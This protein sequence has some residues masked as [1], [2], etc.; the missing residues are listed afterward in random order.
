RGRTGLEDRA[1]PQ[2][3]Y[4]AGALQA[5]AAVT[6]DELVAEGLSGADIGRGM[7]AKRL[8]VIND[9]KKSQQPP[10]S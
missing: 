7:Q 1:Y 6:A 9:Y 5:A 8:S 4:L 2:S 3:A 10:Q